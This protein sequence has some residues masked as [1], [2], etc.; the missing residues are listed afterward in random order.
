MSFVIEMRTKNFDEL[1]ALGGQLLATE[2]KRTVPGPV[3]TRTAV[4]GS[5]T[6]RWCS[7]TPTSRAW[8][9]PTCPRRPRSENQRPLV[10]GAVDVLR[11]RRCRR[12]D[13]R[14]TDG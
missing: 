1:H 12:P 4:T 10:D 6:S 9:T 11:P 5:A 2:G 13:V 8:R 14:S 7:S 3:L